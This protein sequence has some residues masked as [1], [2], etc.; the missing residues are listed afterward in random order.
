MTDDRLFQFIQNLQ[1]SRPWGRVLDAGT[2]RHSLTWIA[3]QSTAGW[4]AV[5]GE[6]DRAKRLQQE[7]RSRMRENDRVIFGNWLDPAFLH[8]DI[9][10]VV[11]ADYLLGSIDGFAPY[12]QDQLFPRLR[13]HVRTRL[14]VVGLQPYDL[15]PDSSAGLIVRE[16]ARLRDACILL[17]GDRCYREYP[18]D[19]TLRHLESAG[20]TV[21]EVQRFP[22]RYS[23]TFVR[24]QLDVC[25]RKLPRIADVTLVSGLRERIGN[26]RERAL[27]L[28]RLAGGIRFGED[29]VV[30]ARPAA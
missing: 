26:L 9:Y 2:G 22:I 30:A 7:F 11:I 28:C 8:Q 24:E 5:T 29:Y 21:E 17:A 16:I 4:T 20:F 12:F 19:W 25:E 15:F 23:D 3:S 10:D 6:A 27:E 18:L 14:Y 13:P 1:G